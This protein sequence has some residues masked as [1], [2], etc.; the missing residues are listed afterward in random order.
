M[1]I[2][3]GREG[4]YIESMRFR[5]P[6]ILEGRGALE[7]FIKG[8]MDVSKSTADTIFNSW[9]EPVKS[10][11]VSTLCEA[12][13]EGDPFEEILKRRAYLYDVWHEGQETVEEA[14]LHTDETA[15]AFAQ[16]IYNLGSESYRKGKIALPSAGRSDDDDFILGD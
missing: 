14:L 7:A 13:R 15:L 5:R 12:L 10:I 1:G 8:E 16:M 11:L 4:E 6:K 9:G 3:K 2:E